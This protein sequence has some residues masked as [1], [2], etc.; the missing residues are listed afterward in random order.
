MIIFYLFIWL[1]SFFCLGSLILRIVL[2][3]EKENIKNALSIPLGGGVFSLFVWLFLFLF[4]GREC[5]P[6]FVVSLFSILSWISVNL[7]PRAKKPH[8]IFRPVCFI[9]GTSVLLSV[10]QALP[11]PVY[12]HDAMVIWAFKSKVFFYEGARALFHPWR[13]AAHLR[14]PW[15]VPL[16]QFAFYR[17]AGCV[18]DRSVMILF[19]FY[20][21][22]LLYLLWA[23]M[24]EENRL[25]LLAFFAFLP[26]YFNSEARI[27]SGYMA[28]P[29]S[30]YFLSTLYMTVKFDETGKSRYLFLASLFS[31]FCLFTKD[32]GILLPF[33]I[34]SYF[35]MKRRKKHL[36]LFLLPFCL[37]ALVWFLIRIR[38]P[39][40][41]DAHYL[42]YLIYLPG[43]LYRIL[44]ILW[45]GIK[46][47]LNP[48]RWSLFF[49]IV[50]S[51]MFLT[52]HR[53]LNSFMK[54]PVLFSIFYLCFSFFIFL[55]PPWAH[56]S[57]QM[58][59][60]FYRFLMHIAPSLL[61]IT[62]Y[63]FHYLGKSPQERGD[64]QPFS[65][66]HGRET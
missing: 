61:W 17:L 54:I 39:G 21:F 32:E 62:S 55:I 4:P 56:Y 41:M 8:V 16:Q 15:L 59:V 3:E 40:R 48:V 49:P 44:R 1:F 34:I 58:R 45:E 26:V 43:N 63:S 20:W 60:T 46:E 22:S 27:S 57:E 31:F 19:P 37:L 47:M 64:P 10:L 14:Y 42:L 11:F 6:I 18:D 51:L 38:I 33:F 13:V 65:M 9:L 66:G 52:R 25:L 53:L 23:I 2:P 30:L 28:L 36:C 5:I 24:K 29:L 12:R 7:I 35:I 50:F